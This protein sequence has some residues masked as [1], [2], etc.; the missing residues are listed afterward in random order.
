MR[1]STWRLVRECFSGSSASPNAAK[2]KHVYGTDGWYTKWVNAQG[3][4]RMLRSCGCS[5]VP[6]RMVR[7]V[8]DEVPAAAAVRMVSP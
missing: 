6:E 1:G 3:M 5:I 2:S 7:C 4:P 8:S